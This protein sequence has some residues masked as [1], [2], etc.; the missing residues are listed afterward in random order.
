MRKTVYQTDTKGYYIGEADSYN[1]LIP[2]GAVET[3]P[4]LSEGYIPC[5]NGTSWEQVE[6]HVGEKGYINNEPFE[7]K[8][9]G[10]YPDGWASEKIYAPH[11]ARAIK[12]SEVPYV[13][14]IMNNQGVYYDAVDEHFPT[15]AFAVAENLLAAQTVEEGSNDYWVTNLDNLQ[16]KLG[17]NNYMQL[18][19][20]IK[21]HYN[22]V[23]KAGIQYRE[24][25]RTLETSEEILALDT[26]EK[27]QEFYSVFYK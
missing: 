7:I 25:L 17:I 10:Q 11:E 1:N 8:E 20:R 19:N 3:A 15:T 22:N 12:D 6:N 9:Y 26:E 16:V 5:W 27:M 23:R 14:E 13:Q 21:S 18:Q 24:F 2:A 4:A